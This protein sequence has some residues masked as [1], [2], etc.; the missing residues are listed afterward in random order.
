MPIN[1]HVYTDTPWDTQTR[2]RAAAVKRLDMW[3]YPWAHM[4]IDGRPFSRRGSVVAPA[5]GVGNQVTLA[6]YEIPP[7]YMGVITH[8][9]ALYVGTGYIEGAGFVVWDIDLNTPL[10]TTPSA[11]YALPDYAAFTM[12]LGDAKYPW[13][14]AGG[15]VADEGE[16]VRVKGRTVATVT[17]GGNT[18]LLGGV[19]G[20]IWPSQKQYTGAGR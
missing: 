11:G 6:E 13:P 8:V 5:F 10:G 3:P 14:L 17:V 20:W 1:N 15:W 19:L 12:S 18:R 4:P 7:G 9:F 2:A 16:T